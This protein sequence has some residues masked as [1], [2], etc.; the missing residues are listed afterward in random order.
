MTLNAEQLI[1][2][3]KATGFELSDPELKLLRCVAIGEIADF[4]TGDENQNNPEQAAAWDSSRCLP[5]KLIKWLCTNEESVKVL[6]HRGLEVTG[7]RIDGSLDLSFVRMEF[8]LVLHRCAFM[9]AVQLE[10]AAVR[11]LDLSGSYITSKQIHDVSGKTLTSALNARGLNVES[12]LL[13]R[14]RLYA[15]GRVSLQGAKIGGNLLCDNSTFSNEEGCS[16]ILQSAEISGF[17]YLS[18]NFKSFGFVSLANVKIN[19]DL[20]C[21]NGKFKHFEMAIFA[22]SSDIKGSVSLSGKDFN[23]DGEVNFQGSCIGGDFN[24]S[25]GKFTNANRNAYCSSLKLSNC[26]VKGNVFLNNSF[27]SIGEVNFQGSCIGRDFNCRDGKFTNVNGNIYYVSL[28]LS[29]CEIKGNVFLNYSFKSIGTVQLSNASIGGNLNCCMGKF[30]NESYGHFQPL[31]LEIDHAEVKGS[32][33]LNFGFH[34]IGT[35]RLNNTVIG[36]DLDCCDAFLEANK[37]INLYRDKSLPQALLIY[38]ENASSLCAN[39][40][41]IQGSLRLTRKFTA[42][43]WISFVNAEIGHLFVLSLEVS[44][45]FSIDLRFAKI[46]AIQDKKESW[47]KAG[48]LDLDGLI[49]ERIAQ[50]SPITG[51]ERLDW[52]RRQCLKENFSPQPYEQV[53]RVLQISGHQ[54]AAIKVLIGE[55]EDRLKYGGLGQFERFWNGFLYHTISHGYKP[56]RALLFSL[57]IIYIGL[58]VFDLGYAQGLIEPSELEAYSIATTKD[59]SPSIPS[60]LGS[61]TGTQMVK[62][63]PAYPEF[64]SLMYSVDVF[65]PIIDFHQESF[66]L[67]KASR[68]QEISPFKLRWGGVLLA[69]FWLHILLGW[70]F[71]SLWV[72]GF[73]GLVKRLE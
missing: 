22:P 19:G 12:D 36:G 71:T 66:W 2:L 15:T 49:Y 67:P 16:L 51:S 28:G 26:E 13:L 46:Y 73:T 48:R 31:S 20:V 14:E 5:A 4:S 60:N 17:V 42:D 6:G 64:Y 30:Y 24:C 1:D 68:G 10:H 29:G 59:S 61:S 57:F 34:S 39:G 53:A 23:A 11:L 69:Y 38:D 33:Q 32:V 52:I 50:G 44:C 37:N 55:Q 21:T 3:V 65:L 58:I 27:E 9:E 7:A 63:P 35:I 40:A 25:D 72:A 47:P 62:T 56:H 45:Q 8:P 54:E 70:I 43:A 18:D 41:S